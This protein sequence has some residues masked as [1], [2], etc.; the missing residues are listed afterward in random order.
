MG[1]AV[2]GFE[3]GEEVVGAPEVGEFVIGFAF[4]MKQ[5]RFVYLQCLEV[6]VNLQRHATDRKKHF[7][8]C[9]PFVTRINA[10][11]PS[12]LHFSLHSY[13][14]PTK[15]RFRS[16]LTSS[17]SERQFVDGCLSNAFSTL[18]CTSDEVQITPIVGAS[19]G[20]EV[21]GFEEGEEV[22]GATVVGSDIVGVCVGVLVVGASLGTEVVGFKVGGVVVGVL[23]VGASV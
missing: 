17:F 2:V 16:L 19:L 1:A 12:S 14:L 23:V 4:G 13:S 5:S 3:V 18:F 11:H 15:I 22:V 9:L 6:D 7:P 21:V 20:T 10:L 8:F